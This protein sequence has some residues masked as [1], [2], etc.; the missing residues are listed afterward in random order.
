MRGWTVCQRRTLTSHHQ[1][2]A[3]I[4]SPPQSTAGRH[5]ERAPRNRTQT[6]AVT[7]IGIS[8]TAK[9]FVNSARPVSSPIQQAVRAEVSPRSIWATATVTSPPRPISRLS[10]L[11]LE[12]MWTSCGT[13]QGTSAATVAATGWGHRRLVAAWASSGSGATIRTLLIRSRPMVTSQRRAS[14]LPGSTLR[15]IASSR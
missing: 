15:I 10:L 12:P 14:P 2:P 8:T 11:T 13:A 6:Y 5:S 3:A 9:N 4:P 1:P 7:I